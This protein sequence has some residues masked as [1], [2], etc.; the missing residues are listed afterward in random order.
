MELRNNMKLREFGRFKKLEVEKASDFRVFLNESWKRRHALY[1]D[2]ALYNEDANPGEQQFLTLD[3]NLVKARNYVGFIGYEGK[4]ITIYP[5]I[6]AEAVKEEDIDGFLMTNLIYWLKRSSRIKFPIVETNLNFNS[7]DSFI[8]ILIYIF[9]MITLDGVYN[10]P[11]NSYEEV[12][13]E[14]PYLKGR[15]NVTEYLKSNISTG[16]WNYFSTIHEP[17]IY[18]NKV[19]KIIKCVSKMLLNVTKNSESSENLNRILFILDEV[20]HIYCGENECDG[21]NI[22]RFNKEYETI[23]ALCEMF[24]KNTS[25]ASAKDNEKLNFC[26]LIPM[27]LLYE[28]FIFNFIKEKFK[29]AYKEITKQKSNLYL[30]ELYVN[31]KYEG[32]LFNLKQDIYLQDREG[33]EII[34]DTKYKL[35]NDNKCD[36]YGIS[37]GDMYQ[38]CSYALRGGYKKLLL[39]YPKSSE[40]EKDVRFV[41]KSGFGNAEIEIDILQ[42]SFLLNYECFSSREN[43]KFLCSMNDENLLKD[44]EGLSFLIS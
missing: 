13:E 44:L 1:D 29:E 17:F 16:R 38:M 37:Q 39:V 2:G 10:D 32:R 27:E 26:F 22:N 18:N 3:G 19:N 35:L 12:E 33:I 40:L 4:T 5:K 43:F 15:L 6:F 23:I 24:L 28:D 34:L 25:L 41:I 14:L 20:E 30:S 21:I 9:S 8:E 42:V 31:D 36:K 11:F 7:M